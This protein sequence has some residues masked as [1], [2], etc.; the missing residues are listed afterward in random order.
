MGFQKKE[1]DYAKELDDVLGLVVKLIDDIKNKKQVE[2]IIGE[3]LPL[4]ISAINGANEIGDEFKDIKIAGQTIGLRLGELIDVI[5]KP[6][7]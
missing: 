4:L 6:K 5:A 1:I 2:A 3:N 7:Q